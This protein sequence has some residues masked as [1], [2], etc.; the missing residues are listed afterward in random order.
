MNDVINQLTCFLQNEYIQEPAQIL[1]SSTANAE[2]SLNWENN[3][4]KVPNNS[5]IHNALNEVY[6]EVNKIANNSFE[7]PPLE[8]DSPRSITNWKDEI[9]NYQTKGNEHIWKLNTDGCWSRNNGIYRIWKDKNFGFNGIFKNM[10]SFLINIY[11]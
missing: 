11:R 4:N 3:W 2:A 10:K 5:E 7:F 1:P 8:D 6:P 9:K